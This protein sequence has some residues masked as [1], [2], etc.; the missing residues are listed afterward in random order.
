MSAVG[1][2]RLGV[3]L[4]HQPGSGFAVVGDQDFSRYGA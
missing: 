3:L 1:P 4:R 2:F